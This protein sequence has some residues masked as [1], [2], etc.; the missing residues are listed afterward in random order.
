MQAQPRQY[1]VLLDL[2]N[3]AWLTWARINQLLFMRV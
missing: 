1:H 2:W 3:L